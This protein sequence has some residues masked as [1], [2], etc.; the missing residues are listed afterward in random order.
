[1][2][3]RL[4]KRAG[5]DDNREGG[6]AANWYSIRR[7]FA[8]FMDEFASDADISAVMG[9]FDISR[10]TRGQLFEKGSPTTDIYK[11]RKLAPVLRISEILE[12]EWWPRIQPFTSINLLPEPKSLMHTDAKEV[13]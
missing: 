12:K 3:Q 5:I 6:A 7:T 13:E 8:D 9:H 4:V 11:R 10:K 1:M 2:I